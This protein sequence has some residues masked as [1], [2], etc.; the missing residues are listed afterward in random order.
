MLIATRS[1][2]VYRAGMCIS[3][4]LRR[5]QT[6]HNMITFLSKITLESIERVFDVFKCRFKR[7]IKETK[8]ELNISLTKS[9]KASLTRLKQK[10]YYHADNR[11]TNII[12][13]NIGLTES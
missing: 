8:I 12:D 9:H 10:S 5:I 4:V 2:M 7:F 11:L 6:S 1:E 3:P 13:Q